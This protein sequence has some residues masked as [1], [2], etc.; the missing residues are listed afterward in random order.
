MEKKKMNKFQ[1]ERQRNKIKW[2]EMIDWRQTCHDGILFLCFETK[3]HKKQVLTM[4]EFPITIEIIQNRFKLFMILIK[5][6]W[7]KLCSKQIA[8]DIE[9]KIQTKLNTQPKFQ[10]SFARR[11]ESK[12]HQ[13]IKYNSPPTPSLHLTCIIVLHRNGFVH[14]QS[15]QQLRIAP[16]GDLGWWFWICIV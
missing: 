14:L 11:H 8:V 4:F 3:L 16:A 1:R 10:F 13:K 9:N 7:T 15:T 6:I 12:N 2:I 5:S